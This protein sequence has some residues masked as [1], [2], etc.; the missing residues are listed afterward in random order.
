MPA[1]AQPDFATVLASEADRRIGGRRCDRRSRRGLAGENIAAI[2]LGYRGLSL[3]V[4][5]AARQLCTE[6]QVSTV[7]L[8][9]GVFQNQLLLSMLNDALSAKGVAVWT[10]R[11]VPA[12]DGGLSLGQAAIASLSAQ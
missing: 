2:A 5:Q 12:G 4:A 3:A 9:G 8:T 7:V 11:T 1:R 10:N 6:H